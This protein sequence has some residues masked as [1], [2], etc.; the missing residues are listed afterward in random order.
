MGGGFGGAEAF[1]GGAEPDYD[2][3]GRPDW[4]VSGGSVMVRHGALGMLLELLRCSSRRAESMQS[5][6]SMQSMQSMQRVQSM[7]S[8][9]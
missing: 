2:G 6:Q 3:D 4:A 7:Q 9:Q 5:I 1:G 8:M